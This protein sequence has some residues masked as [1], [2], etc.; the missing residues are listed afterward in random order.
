MRRRKR[1]D[2]GNFPS[3]EERIDYQLD[4]ALDRGYRFRETDL[5]LYA[6]VGE[7]Q[8]RADRA[9]SIVEV[10]MLRDTVRN[11]IAAL[12]FLSALVL[13]LVVFAV[14]SVVT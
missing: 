1:L 8:G 3:W 2:A 10:E 4:C 14:W 7:L 6:K 12:V 9:A 11:Y 13:A 5:D